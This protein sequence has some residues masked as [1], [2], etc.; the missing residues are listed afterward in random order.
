MRFL[1]LG[2]A[3]AFFRFQYASAID[4]DI[5]DQ[6][7]IKDAAKNV[8]G[9]IMTL[10]H[11]S[12]KD[13]IG[14]FEAPYYWWESGAVWDAFIDYWFLTGDDQYNDQV[15]ASLFS[16]AGQDLDFMP[17]NQTKDEVS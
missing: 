16:Q 14:I 15:S 3:A 11:S 5:N 13:N 8:T 4:L 1:A 10:Y 12:D 9:D 2:V 7:S 6:N 17:T